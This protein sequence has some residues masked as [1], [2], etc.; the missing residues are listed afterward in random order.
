MSDLRKLTVEELSRIAKL[1]N[2]K[3]ETKL[4]IDSLQELSAKEMNDGGMNS[5]LLVP[6]NLATSDRRFG[7]RIASGEFLDKDGALVSIVLNVDQQDFLFE[8][9]VWKVDFT[10][11]LE[12]PNVDAIKVTG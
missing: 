2:G 11:V 12:W 5:L 10:P 4:Y 8:F 6:N 1:L 3:Q 9:D 7:K